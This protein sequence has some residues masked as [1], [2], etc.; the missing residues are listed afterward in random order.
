VDHKYTYFSLPL[1]ASVPSAIFGNTILVLQEGLRR[2]YVLLIIVEEIHI[3][4]CDTSNKT[5]NIRIT[6]WFSR[7]TTVAVEIKKFFRYIIKSFI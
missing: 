1:P 2:L 3:I 5:G 4:Y 7:I 6:L